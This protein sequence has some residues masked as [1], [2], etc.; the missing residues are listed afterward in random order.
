MLQGYGKE[1]REGKGREGRGRVEGRMKG[2]SRMGCGKGG[3]GR[4]GKGGGRRKMVESDM[5][6]VRNRRRQSGDRQSWGEH[7]RG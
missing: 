1:R 7:C 5:G 3:L 2:A 4:A 6:K